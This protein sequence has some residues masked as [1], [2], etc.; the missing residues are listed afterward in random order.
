[1]PERIHPEIPDEWYQSG[2]PESDVIGFRDDLFY[3]H[4]TR[5]GNTLIMHYIFSKTPTV[6]NTQKF[7]QERIDEG[8]DIVIVNPNETMVHICEKFGFTPIEE[9]LDGYYRGKSVMCWRKRV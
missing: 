8:W 2:T 3:G 5:D 1:M 6:G 9:A 4:F 7:I